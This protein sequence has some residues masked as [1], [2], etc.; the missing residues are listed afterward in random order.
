MNIRISDLK[1]RISKYDFSIAGIG[2]I[3]LI[4]LAGSMGLMALGQSAP[5]FGTSRPNMQQSNSG[6]QTNSDQSREQRRQQRRGM[7]RRDEQD[8][9]A[10]TQPMGAMSNLFWILTQRSIFYHG[11]FIPPSTFVRG[12]T[13]L[14]F[15]R[16]RHQ[17]DSLVF[18]GATETDGRIE[19]F[20][21]DSDAETESIVEVGDTVALG[22]ISKITLNELDYTR[23]GNETV[24]VNI[25][26]NLNGEN[27][28][29]ATTLPSTLP[30][31]DNGG[32]DSDVL[33][34]L[35]A[36]RLKEIH[37]GG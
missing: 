29:D 16:R 3:C 21:E 30:S 36:R 32:V 10:A 34:R 27:V 4:V 2:L 9:P 20:L 23:G 17:E 14:D 6:D 31:G 33:A 5:G 13:N 15:E 19:G 8:P 12:P 26:H 7:R 25:G 18:N 1:S 35:R 24:H 37:G 11:H 22:K 28:W